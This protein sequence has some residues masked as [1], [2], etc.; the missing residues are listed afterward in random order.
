MT[1]RSLVSP[2]SSRPVL[3][4]WRPFRN[5]RSNVDE[6]CVAAAVYLIEVSVPLRP[7][8]KVSFFGGLQR[9]PLL[10]QFTTNWPVVKVRVCVRVR[11]I[12]DTA[13]T[14]SRHTNKT[15]RTTRARSRNEPMR[16]ELD[17][18]I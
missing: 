6:Q 2:G 18:A 17:V 16:A 9:C 4:I 10:V 11:A 3:A 1:K 14:A 15:K 8:L 13:D 12:A 5:T 7:S